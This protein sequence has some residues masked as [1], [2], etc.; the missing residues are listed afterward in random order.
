MYLKS[1]NYRQYPSLYPMTLI[2]LSLCLA[3]YVLHISPLF[4]NGLLYYNGAGVN[5]YIANGEWWRLLTPIFLHISFSHFLFNSLS[6]LLF[7]PLLERHLGSSLF[8]GFFLLTGL[9]ANIATYLFMPLSYVHV[10]AS[11]S[12][13]GLLG[14]YLYASIFHKQPVPKQFETTIYSLAIF[15]V[16]MSL[17]EPNI[18]LIGHFTGLIAGFVF[19]PFFQKRSQQL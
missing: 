1:D 17:I 5:L 13:M 8:A 12:I 10:G 16:I 3:V 18:N 2:I 4:P 15:A 6:I 19:A 11:N 14:F 9:I 7:G